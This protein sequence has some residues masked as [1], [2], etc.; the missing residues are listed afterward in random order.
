MKRRYLSAVCW[1]ALSVIPAA[2]CADF[3]PQQLIPVV[4]EATPSAEGASTAEGAPATAPASTPLPIAGMETPMVV[5]TPPA[6]AADEFYACPTGDCPGGCGT[7]C[8]TATPVTGPLAPAPTDWENLESWLAILWR[9]NVNPAAVRAALQ[10]S[11][12]QRGL[13]DWR[14][15]DFDG[16]LRDEWVLV[17]YD[18]SMPGTVFGAAGDLWIVNDTGAIFRYYTAPS[19]DI[20]DFLAPTIVHMADLTGDGLP[21]LITDVT[22]CG[23]HT[24][25]N[26]YRIIGRREGQLTDLQ[27][28]AA[29]PPQG[30]DGPQPITMTYAD[31]WLSDIDDDG[32]QEFLVHGGTIGSVG[33]GVIR[34]H[35]E[36]WG[37][38]GT[39]VT[40][41][42]T[43]LDPTQYRHHILYEANDRMAAGD[44]D[45]ALA[46]YESAINDGT[47]RDDGFWHAPEQIRADIS[48]FA[49]FRLILIDLLQGNAERANSRLAWLGATYP[50][51]AAARAAGTL[52]AE[53]AGPEGA[54]ALC[55]RIENSLAAIENPTG[56]LA[57]MGYGNP[58]LGAGDFC[59]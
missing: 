7:V 53:W 38:D 12:M 50:G 26:S 28:V 8:V 14:A 57:D 40:L 56:V 11:G 36:V 22:T 55:D 27:F 49:A 43:I 20:Y 37:W 29:P 31:T 48:A 34:P 46:L 3:D 41:A 4:G 59:P 21:E 6:C 19:G 10:Q 54:E 5:C 39:A 51:S 25:T 45:G 42:E 24:C 18:Q 32:L 30:A 33:G 13:D 35:T 23:V 58:S 9:S 17:L 2:G 47:W 15:A 16:D 52:V 44:L 1:L